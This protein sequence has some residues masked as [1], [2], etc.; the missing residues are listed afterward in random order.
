M[1][2]LLDR[3]CGSYLVRLSENRKGFPFSL[4]FVQKSREGN[5]A[6]NN[7]RIKLAW[8]NGKPRYLLQGVGKIQTFRKLPDAIYATPGVERNMP[9]PR[10]FNIRYIS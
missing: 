4:S 9:C 1:Y 6:I 3:R 2:R 5:V 10:D 7:V 8:N